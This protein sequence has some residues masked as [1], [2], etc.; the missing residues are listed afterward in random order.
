MTFDEHYNWAKDRLQKIEVSSRSSKK[1]V[2]IK[3]ARRLEKAG[4]LVETICA[5]ISLKLA[6]EGFVTERYVREVLTDPKFKRKYENN[7]IEDIG[8]SC[9]ELELEKDKTQELNRAKIMVSNTGKQVSSTLRPRDEDK[10]VPVSDLLGLARAIEDR[11][12]TIKGLKEKYDDMQKLITSRE[13]IRPER[14]SKVIE[15]LKQDIE[16]ANIEI[17]FLKGQN[18]GERIIALKTKMAGDHPGQYYWGTISIQLLKAKIQE[19]EASGIK[20]VEI[21]LRIVT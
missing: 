14:E 7:C 6:S 10:L 5:N 4:M 13:K 15:K 11:D 16:G 12:K 20:E 8:T 3:L 18:G 21:F 17:D 2:I 9:S 1:Q 19:L